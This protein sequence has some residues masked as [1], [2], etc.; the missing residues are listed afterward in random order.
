MEASATVENFYSRYEWCL[1]PILSVRQLLYRFREELSAYRQFDGWQREECKINLYLFACAIACTADDYFNLKR[2]DLSPLS[3][4]LP[5]FR[6]LLGAAELTFNTLGWLLRIA[7]NWRAWRWRKHWNICLEGV[8][9]LLVGGTELRTTTSTFIKVP[10]PRQLL[11]WKMRLPEAFRGQDFTHHDVI[12]LIQRFCDSCPSHDQPLTIIGLRTAGAYFAPLMAAYLKRSNYSKVSWFSIRPKNGTSTWETKQ[13]RSLRRDSKVL[14]VDDYPAT[15]DTLRLTLRILQQSWITPEQICILAPTHA[16][17]PDWIKLAQIDDRIKIFTLQPAELFKVSLLKP[18][19]VE[20]WCGEYFMPSTA[21]AFRLIQD[22]GL[23]EL[24]ARLAEHSKD[25]HHVRE[26]RVF[27]IQLG[28]SQGGVQ[29]RRILV[30]SVGWGWLGYH[31]YIAGNRLEGFVPRVFGL[32]NGLLLMEWIDDVAQ[33][34]KRVDEGVVD[35]LASYVAAR[36]S[37]LRLPGDFRFE[38]R[39]YRWTGIDDI[40]AIL[41]AA[42]GPYLSRLKSPR[43]RKE[44]YKYAATAPTLI[45]GRMRPDEWLHTQRSIYKSDFEHHNFGGAEPDLADPAYDLAGA[46]FE[47]Q[48]D[49]KYEER[50]LHTYIRLSDDR[51]ISERII[52][53]KIFYASMTM[54]HAADRVAAGKQPEQNH[55]LYHRARNFLIYSMNEFCAGLMTVPSSLRWSDSLFFIDVD[56]VFDQEL[57]GFPHATQS[58]LRSLALLQ[59]NGY[60]VVLNTGR[61][62]EHV[63]QYCDTYGIPGGIAEF[64]GVFFDAVQKKDVSLIDAETVRQLMKCR[65]ALRALPGVF[66][67]PGYKYSIR[68]YRFKKRQSVGLSSEEIGTLLDKPDFSRLDCIARGPD[69]YIHQKSANKGSGLM[70]VKRYLNNDRPTTAIGH[71]DPDIPMLQASDYAYALEN[72]SPAVRQMAKQGHCR[73]VRKPCQSGLLAAV[74]HRL[75][76]DGIQSRDFSL[77]SANAGHL[78]GLMP[79]LLRAADRQHSWQAL[80]DFLSWSL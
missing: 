40:V 65:Q 35:A 37:R 48:L 31:A 24:N 1:N 6:T 28:D 68:A 29:N 42:Y 36:T 23:D 8:C 44:L 43:L 74:E 76:S 73:M 39:T 27:Q 17:Q 78:D 14:V 41:R 49:K 56:G 10:L 60:S 15:G 38:S 54:R 77:P 63:R 67:D 69:T 46:I 3:S 62:I 19:A 5:R 13:L 51:T 47:F 52:L 72:C 20:P 11:R 61:S 7:T 64:G 2:T 57:L 75:A 18:Q 34:P 80:A 30:K 79:Q 45:D 16:A 71:S 22:R 32:R 26:K 33:A 9:D 58:G 66:I 21:A 53:H 55:Q 4:N 70:F 59:S 25:G 50:L 12:S